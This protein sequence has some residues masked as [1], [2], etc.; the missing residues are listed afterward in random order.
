MGAAEDVIIT[1]ITHV[2]IIQTLEH[3]HQH[4]ML[5]EI[6]FR[7]LVIDPVIQRLTAGAT[8]VVARGLVV[9]EGNNI[10]MKG[11]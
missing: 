3:Q 4:A 7:L 2:K 6:Q 11:Y 9:S 8:E 1:R 5:T 10:N